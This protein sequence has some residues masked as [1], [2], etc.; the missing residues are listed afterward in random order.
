[1]AITLKRDATGLCRCPDGSLAICADCDCSYT[2]AI[3]VYLDGV[4]P[5]VVPYAPADGCTWHYQAMTAGAHPFPSVPSFNAAAWML[6]IDFR[7]ISTC[8]WRIEVQLACWDSGSN[9]TGASNYHSAG[10]I[11]SH[12]WSGSQVLMYMSEISV[13]EGWPSAL[14]SSSGVH[15]E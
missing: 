15:V 11:G 8:A 4:G 9:M 12:C 5:F 1:M 14:D 2:G 13:G 7:L 6:V 3:D 10:S